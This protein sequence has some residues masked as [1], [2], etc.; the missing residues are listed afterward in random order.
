MDDDTTLYSIGELARLTGLTVKTIRF[1]SDTGVVPPTDRTPAG[2]RLYGPD[3]LA[4]LGLVRTLRELGVGLSAV[5]RVLG[6]EV[7]VARIAAVHAEALDRQIRTLRLHR[8]VLRAVAVRGS[9]PEEMELMHKL[10]NLSERERR[11]LIDDFIDHAFEGIDVDPGFLTTLRDAMPVLPDAPTQAQ[12][13]AWVELAE[14]VQDDDFRAGMRRAAIDQVRA[15][16]E[17]GRPDEQEARRLA[18]LI[19]ERTAG[20][21]EAEVA[22][23]SPAARPVVEELVRESARLAGREDGP[24]FRAWLLERLEI[25]SDSRYEHYW[26]LVSVINGWPAPDMGPAVKWLIASLRAYP[27]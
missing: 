20:A 21:R 14:L 8:A 5:Q 7:S 15:R 12:V 1:W 19:R 10:V 3:A 11:R 13:E 9:T 6:R 24:G 4:R 25:G 26:R 18:E 2:Y 22:P 16:E 27:A 23:D 17:A